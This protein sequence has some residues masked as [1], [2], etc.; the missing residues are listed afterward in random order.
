MAEKGECM[1]KVSKKLPIIIGIILVVV[2]AIVGTIVVVANKG[3]RVIKVDKV[4]GEASL[5]RKDN[6]Q[7][8]YE[9]INLQSEDAVITGQDGQVELLIDSDKHIWAQEN[10]KFKVVSSGDENKGKLKIELQYGTSLV[11]IE[12]KLPEGAFFEVETP[13]ATIGVR[14]TVFETSYCK[15]ENRTVVA[16]ISGVVEITTDT[17][18]VIVETGQSAIVVDDIVEGVV[19]NNVQDVVGDIAESEVRKIIE[20][21]KSKFINNPNIEDRYY[22]EDIIYETE[23]YKVQDLAVYESGE[24]IILEGV[25]DSSITYISVDDLGITS[26]IGGH[27]QGYSVGV[28]AKPNPGY[29]FVGCESDTLEFFDYGVSGYG[30]D[31]PGYIVPE[32][33]EHIIYVYYAPNE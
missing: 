8:I 18:N 16:V 13:N 14:G 23:I 24:P 28:E 29:H 1:K 22:R 11:E 9:N 20:Y 2:I 4:S 19:E 12:E 15:E 26:G 32:S 6:E 30:Y 31:V 21:D 25:P 5:E 7:E 10:T 17:E 27:Y 33:G 3:H